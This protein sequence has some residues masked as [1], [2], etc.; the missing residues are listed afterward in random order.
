MP[1]SSDLLRM[2]ASAAPVCRKKSV[3]GALSDLS[4]LNQTDKVHCKESCTPTGP[5]PMNEAL[6]G[7]Y[8][9]ELLPIRGNTAFAPST[10]AG[11]T[12]VEGW[13]NE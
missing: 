11:P 10:G 1:S 8:A 5:T 13:S 7:K 12:C 9:K 2:A 6:D 3:R 4:E